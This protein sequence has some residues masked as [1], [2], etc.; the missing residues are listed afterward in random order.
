MFRRKIL[1]L[2]LCFSQVA[3][4]LA[5]SK[6]RYVMGDVPTVRYCDLIRHPE[7]YHQ[8]VVRV[9]ARYRVGAKW[10]NLYDPNCGRLNQ[11]W[12]NFDTTYFDES[13]KPC[14]EIN[15]AEKIKFKGYDQEFDAILVGKFYG[16]KET[17]YGRDGS[18]FMLVVSCVEQATL[19]KSSRVDVPTLGYCDLVRNPQLY[20]NR[21]IRVRG[22]YSLGFESSTLS[23]SG[24]EGMTW[25][26]F[27]ELYKTCTRKEVDTALDA[28]MSAGEPESLMERKRA[29]VVFL[30]Y[31]E[32][33]PNY[34]IKNELVR[35]GFGHMGMYSNRIT[36]KCLE[37]A[38]PLTGN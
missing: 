11:T 36:V 32:V 34:T 7:S 20:D 3:A 22:A 35:N 18:K 14:E 37:N 29:D 12:I 4:P 28:L 38:Q 26:D 24:C 21:V 15:V 6:S 17:D 16:S 23:S 2:L 31:F 8:T 1:L 30:G 10:S 9:H 19:V 13:F 25:I 27:D 33:L 5:I